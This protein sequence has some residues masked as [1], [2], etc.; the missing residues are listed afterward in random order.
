MK[1]RTWVR[2]LIVSR[3]YVKVVAKAIDPAAVTP[4]RAKIWFFDNSFFILTP[5]KENENEND[6]KYC[7]NNLYL[8]W[9]ELEWIKPWLNPTNSQ[10]GATYTNTMA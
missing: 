6:E 1:V 8:Y 4:W 7:N 10:T 2:T 5:E 3:G 9:L